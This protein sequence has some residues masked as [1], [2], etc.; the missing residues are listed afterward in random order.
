MG[1]ITGKKK[2][3]V[4][5]VSHWQI[6]YVFLFE[7]AGGKGIHRKLDPGAEYR[8][9]VTVSYSPSFSSKKS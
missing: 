8:S 3:F 2:F 5:I 9:K 6:S 1:R 7:T 4:I